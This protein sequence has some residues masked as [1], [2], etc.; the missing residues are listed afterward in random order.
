MTQPDTTR[1][2]ATVW[3][4]GIASLGLGLRLWGSSFGLPAVYNP[5]EAAIMTRALAFGTGDLNPHN[6]LYPTLY[7]YVLFAWEG[8]TFVVLRAAGVYASLAEFTTAFFV[9][10][11]WIY[12]TGRWLSALCGALTVVA[13][14]RLGSRLLTRTT[15]L[16]AAAVLAVSPIAVR[17]AHYVKHDVPVTLLIVLTHVALAGLVM[18]PSARRAPRRWIV[19]GGLAG[20]A[21]STHYYAVF[22]A[23]PLLFVAW[24]AAPQPTPRSRIGHVW[25]LGLCAAAAFAATSPFVILEPAT[26]YRDIVANR[27]I[28]MDR[29]MAPTGLFPSMGPYLQLLIAEG[30]TTWGTV[31]AMLGGVVLVGSGLRASVLAL[32]FPVAFMLFIANTVPASRYLNPVLPFFALGAGA[33]LTWVCRRLPTGRVDPTIPVTLVLCAL[34]AW[35]SANAGTFFK[36]ADTRALALQHIE[37]TVPAGSTILVQPYGV[38]VRPSRQSL[39]EALRL[40]V[41]SEAR[42]SVKFQKMLALDPYPAPAYRVLYLG[43]G[44]LDPDKIYVDPAN[45]GQ[46]GLDPLRA[47]GVEYVVLRRYN[48]DAPRD[49]EALRERLDREAHRVA[50]FS[51]VRDEFAELAD[52]VPPFLHNTDARLDA[53]LARPG[54]A[55]D[56]WRLN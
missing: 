17:D 50:S 52:V 15:G 39:V 34:A 3:L 29:A 25:I 55:L 4:I 5:D 32:S 6:F 18:S 27:Q 56:I 36:Q 10:P 46:A 49:L 12:L 37:R 44:G 1:R 19:A 48:A 2:T 51:P 11:S 20:L 54:P 42:A 38:P 7:F 23:I 8:L 24:R 33:G 43:R 26:A 53:R 16:I 13:T 35:T 45:L 14:Y 9:D 21:I 40:H 31:A 47:L 22:V 30:L 28:V 41:G